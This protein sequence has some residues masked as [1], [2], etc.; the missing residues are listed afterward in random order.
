[1]VLQLASAGKSATVNLF[2]TDVL[3]LSAVPLMPN[4]VLIGINGSALSGSASVRNKFTVA[5]FPA[6]ASCNTT[7]GGSL[8]FTIP[9]PTDNST[10]LLAVPRGGAGTTGLGLTAGSPRFK[11]SVNYF[12]TDGF[13][14]SMP[15]VGA[16]NA[17]TPA[18]ALTA[19]GSAVP[20]GGAGSATVTV[21]AAE[22]ALSPALGVMVLAP[23]NVSGA[24]QAV[25]IPIL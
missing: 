25:L 24:S 16:F 21:N 11:Y 10:L 23:D 1:M 19:G 13:S 17:F 18:V 6:D 4:K 7:G 5:L 20:A 14:A 2:R 22:Q 12:G 3:E 15:G 9:Q 8:L